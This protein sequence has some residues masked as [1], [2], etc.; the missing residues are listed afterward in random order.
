MPL[1]SAD[2]HGVQPI[3]DQGNTDSVCCFVILLVT[4]LSFVRHRIE[5]TL[6]LTIQSVPH[7]CFVCVHAVQHK[8]SVSRVEQGAHKC[9]V[10]LPTR[11]TQLRR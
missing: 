3:W 2:Y 5:T 10:Q 9:P 7:Y 4:I 8:H 1:E 11:N 6:L